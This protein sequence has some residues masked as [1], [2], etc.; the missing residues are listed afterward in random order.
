MS[1]K[2][3]IC[4]YALSRLGAARI[5]S[6]TDNTSEARLCNVLLDDAI[7]EVLEEGDWRFASRRTSLNL[8]TNTPE[9]GF[10]DEFQLPTNPKALIVREINEARAGDHEYII[11]GDK[12][13]ANISTMDIRYTALITDTGSFPPSFER[14]LKIRMQALLA[15]NLTGNSNL[16]IQLENLYE[17]T[18]DKALAIDGQQGSKDF[19]FATDLHDVRPL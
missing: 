9:F 12:L 4:N 19:I 18:V 16:I 8:T 2:V 3:Q 1:S 15:Y 13:L 17:N 14:C 6:L 10:T 5:T 7:Q 11:E